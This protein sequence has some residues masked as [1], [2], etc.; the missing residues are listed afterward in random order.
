LRADSATARSADAATARSTDA[1][2]IATAAAALNLLLIIPALQHGST[3]SCAS[4]ALR[5]EAEIAGVAAAAGFAGDVAAYRR[6]IAEDPQF[7]APS[8][9]ALRERVEVIAK[10][11]DRQ[12]PSFFGRVP[13]ITYGVE[14]IPA[15]LAAR[16]P[17]AYA[18]P[19]PGDGSTSGILWVSGIPS[20]CP[21]YLAPSLALHE[22]WPGHLMH[23]A[24]MQEADALPAFRRFN[25]VKHTACLEGWA[26]YCE[27]LGEEMKLYETPHQHFGQL[28][29]EMWRACRLVV[30]TGLHMKGWTRAQAQAYLRDHTALSEHEVTTE[31]DRYIGWPGQALS[32]KAGEIE[33]RRLRTEAEATLGTRFDLRAFHDHV[34]AQ[35][36]VPLPAL[37]NQVQTWAQQQMAPA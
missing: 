13:R 29:M 9:E 27:G 18:Q 16:M 7:V 36:C 24:L 12:I 15:A 14:S 23:I 30:D 10:R 5:I 1:A 26:L 33:F 25:A 6:F 20:M 34:L 37:R 32:Y 28:D 11:I 35:G 22:G 3:H 17:P 4:E 2:A 19:N 31:V 8:A 21:L